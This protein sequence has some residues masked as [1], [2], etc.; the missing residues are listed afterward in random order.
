MGQAKYRVSFKMIQ[1]KHLKKYADTIYILENGTISN[2]GS[3]EDLLESD[4]FYSLYW[5]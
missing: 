2:Y 3:H 4:N 1:D 5:K